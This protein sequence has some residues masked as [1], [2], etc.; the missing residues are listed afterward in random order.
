MS[1]NLTPSISGPG[2]AS[3]VGIDSGP[4]NRQGQGLV[5]AQRD[6]HRPAGRG[7]FFWSQSDKF[8]TVDQHPPRPL[9]GGGGGIMAVPSALLLMSGYI[10]FAVGSTLGLAAIVLGRQLEAGTPTLLAVAVAIALG[11]GHRRG[12]GRAGHKTAVRADRGEP[13]LLHRRSGFHAGN[14]RRRCPQRMG[15]ELSGARTQPSSRNTDSVSRGD[16]GRG[17]RRRRHFPYQDDLGAGM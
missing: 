3:T 12:P 11:G 14:Q 15:Q 5:S 6:S 13:R 7:L 8:M 2:P 9:A 16:C 4:R 1:E 10:D 17:L